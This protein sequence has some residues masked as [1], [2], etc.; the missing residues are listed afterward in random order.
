M[1]FEETVQKQL[2]KVNSTGIRS[3]L[4]LTVASTGFD[5]LRNESG[6]FYCSVLCGNKLIKWLLV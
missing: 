1:Q 6:S 4:T 2:D 3:R 5:Q